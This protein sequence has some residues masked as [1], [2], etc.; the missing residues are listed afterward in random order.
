MH[1]RGKEKKHFK[2]N[3]KQHFSDP[4]YSL[5]LCVE[6]FLS[7]EDGA[8]AHSCR[9]YGA[10]GPYVGPFRAIDPVHATLM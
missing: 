1:G 4:V 9:S 8:S 6:I 3:L 2:L 7:T 10:G 5:I